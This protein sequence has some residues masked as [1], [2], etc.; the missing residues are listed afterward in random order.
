MNFNIWLVLNKLLTRRSSFCNQ[1][2]HIK[3]LASL[4]LKYRISLHISLFYP[5]GFICFFCVFSIWNQ[6]K[7]EGWQAYRRVTLTHLPPS[8]F[9][10]YN[11][12]CFYIEKFILNW[13]FGLILKIL[14]GKSHGCICVSLSLRFR[15]AKGV[16]RFNKLECFC[17][18]HKMYHTLGFFKNLFLHFCTSQYF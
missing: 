17:M 9:Q 4:L 2:F 1:I 12:Y 3:I 11:F 18:I 14:F 13:N 5:V 15:N 10:S 16:Q 6:R 8:N 7:S